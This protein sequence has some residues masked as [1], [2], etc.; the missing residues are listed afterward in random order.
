M[1]SED[2]NN[3]ANQLVEEA[4]FALKWL[5]HVLRKTRLVKQSP[6]HQSSDV[7]IYAK[8]VCI[9]VAGRLGLSELKSELEDLCLEVYAPHFYHAVSRLLVSTGE[10]R[11]QFIRRFGGDLVVLLQQKNLSFSIQ[12]RIKSIASI[13]GKL[14]RLNSG[15]EEIYDVF[16]IRLVLDVPPS[17]E[18]KICWQVYEAL[19]YAYEV[20]EKKIRNWLD[21]PRP[22][23]YQALHLTLRKDRGPWVEVQIRTRRMNKVAESGSAAHWKYKGTSPGDQLIQL[24]PWLQQIRLALENYPHVMDDELIT[25]QWSPIA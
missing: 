22:S 15:L 8:L 25:V 23:G 16:A 4:R 18:Y 10:E 1:C 5:C 20:L 24:E 11:I 3:S 12:S 17:R 21:N 9:P 13:V 7:I 6:L 19:T 2:P 14:K